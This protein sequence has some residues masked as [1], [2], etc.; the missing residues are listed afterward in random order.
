MPSY[1]CEQRIHSVIRV[2]LMN[3]RNR[4]AQGLNEP[5]EAHDTPRTTRG[6]TS[7][8]SQENQNEATAAHNCCWIIVWLGQARWCR[9]KWTS[10]A[11]EDR[12]SL[13][14]FG[15]DG[16]YWIARWLIVLLFITRCQDT[17]V[18]SRNIPVLHLPIPPFA[19]T[20]SCLS[21]IFLNFL[22]QTVWESI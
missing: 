9:W 14:G 7:H 15:F 12:V 11:Y 20:H 3:V 1:E 19:S 8:L 5:R 16:N 4:S 13:W 6:A 18:T 2:W 22:C 21:L 10:G 17:N